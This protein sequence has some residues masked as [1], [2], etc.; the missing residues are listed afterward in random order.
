MQLSIIIP[1]LNEKENILALIP[2]IRKVLSG[3]TVDY[4]I[5]VIDGGSTDGTGKAADSLGAKI[6]R[7]TRKGYGGALRDGFDIANGSYILTLDADMSHDPEFIRF[8]W[9]KRHLAEIIIAS[10]YVPGG[11][12]IM[13]LSRKVL[14]IIL[15]V[16]FSRILSLPIK[17]LSSGFRFYSKHILDHIE[18]TGENFEILEEILIK[19]YMEGYRVLE[20]P[21]VYVPRKSGRSKA[22]LLKFGF[23]LIKTLFKMRALRNSIESA[24]YDERAFNSIIPL[25][26]YWQRKRHD[27]ITKSSSYYKPMLDIGCG[28]SRILQSLHHAIGIDININRLRY[29]RKYNVPLLNGSI[30]SLP[31]KNNSF[32]CVICS[33]VIEHIPFDLV[34]FDEMTRVL[35]KGGRLIIGTP[36]YSKINWRIIK[37]LYDFFTPEGHKDE[38]I[39]FYTRQ[40]L[41]EIL[42][43]KGFV[44]EAMFYILRAEL[45]LKFEKIQ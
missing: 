4:E 44:L 18:L 12:A 11:A 38:H 33:Q 41:T 7:Q 9:Q 16:V 32:E 10:R 28:S 42:G 39:T 22:K 36:D 5:I 27:I 20:I 31:F 19:C 34:I 35:K 40:K 2:A 6:I 23:A 14:S 3:I 13:P 1:T 21:L 25:Q 30:F 8:M 37:P 29:M 17:D 26:R 24:D 15:N 43:K 45:I